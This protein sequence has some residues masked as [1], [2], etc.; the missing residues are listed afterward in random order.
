MSDAELESYIKSNTY[1]PE[2]LKHRLEME[3]SKL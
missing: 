3:I 1:N 2:D